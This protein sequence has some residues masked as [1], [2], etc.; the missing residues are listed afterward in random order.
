M[1]NSFSGYAGRTPNS[2]LRIVPRVSKIENFTPT[3]YIRSMKSFLFRVFTPF[4]SLNAC[5]VSGTSANIVKME[6]K[7]SYASNLPVNLVKMSKR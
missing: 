2:I 3:F 4:S 7:L 5:S 6:Y 1:L